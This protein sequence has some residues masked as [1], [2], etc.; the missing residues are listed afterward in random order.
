MPSPSRIPLFVTADD[1]AMDPGIDSGILE[2][3]AAGGITGVAIW[4]AAAPYRFSAEQRHLLSQVDV[5]LHWGAFPID[6]DINR[7]GEWPRLRS[8]FR[9]STAEV[10][11]ARQAWD[12]AADSLT[13]LGLRPTFINGH[14][15]VH[16]FPGWVVPFTRWA[17]GR[18]M[19]VMRRPLEIGLSPWE[20][21]RKRPAMA[22]LTVLGWYASRRGR[23]FSGTWVPAICRWGQEFAWETA[24]A[25]LPRATATEIVLHPGRPTPEFLRITRMPGDHNGQLAQLL[26]PYLPR[27]LA[28][29]PF[30]LARFSGAKTI[31]SRRSGGSEASQ[32]EYGKQ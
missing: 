15:H 27:L 23:R 24:L 26:R 21:F 22:V 5:G 25:E 11:A 7:P 13:G 20:Y 4:V 9:P 31:S 1:F 18:G 16:L 19:R 10:T 8:L 17:E 2:G 29:T 6:A 28:D 32:G 12:R 3:I 30:V 14:Q